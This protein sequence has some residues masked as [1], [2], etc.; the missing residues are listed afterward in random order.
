MQG[1]LSRSV[2]NG[3]GDAHLKNFA[4]E[5]TNR[6][7]VRL[8]PVYDVLTGTVYPKYETAI[9]ALTLR[10]K[11]VWASGALLQAYG[12]ARL[13][14]SKTDMG[15]AIERVTAA[16]YQVTPT[17][18]EFA[19]RYPAFR[20][21]AKRMLDAWACGLADIKP[22]AKPGKYKPAPLREQ[23]GISDPSPAA[24]RKEANPYVNADGAF[25]HKSR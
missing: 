4:L 21:V 24:A 8:A 19:D 7:D 14:L 16:V 3:I 9:P 2:E 23:M 1:D 22:D 6:D 13:G 25:S 15:E 20:E 12:G 17:V 11:R 10:G 5:Y 18:A